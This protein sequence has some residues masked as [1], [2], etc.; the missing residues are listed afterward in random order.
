M[1]TTGDIIDAEG[2][3]R[4]EAQEDGSL[5][6][7]LSYD[8]GDTVVDYLHTYVSDDFRGH[9]VGSALA[10]AALQ[11]ARHRGLRVRPSCPFLAGWLA[12]HPD[13]QDLVA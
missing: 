1:T 3:G 6:G 13:Y 9:G 4:F 10:Q 8:R 11:D 5:A 2:R 7:Y 12:E